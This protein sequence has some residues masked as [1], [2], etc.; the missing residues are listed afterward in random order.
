MWGLFRTRCGCE[1]LLAIPNPPPQRY[2]LPMRVRYGLGVNAPALQLFDPDYN[3]APIRNEERQ[4][5]RH[6][7]TSDGYA[8]YL[9]VE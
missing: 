1:R 9:E 2:V 5:S 3:E 8:L 4:F 7:F 6:G